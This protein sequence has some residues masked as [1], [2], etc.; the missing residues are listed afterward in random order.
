ME[1]M[2]LTQLIYSTDV[3]PPLAL[4]IFN[5]RGQHS[6]AK[7]FQRTPAY[8]DEVTTG[9]AKFMAELAIGAGFEVRITNS[10]DFLVFHAVG[11]KVQF[12]EDTAAFWR[13]LAE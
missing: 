10:D 12:P 6:G 5:A 8:P 13:K 9:R 2:E 11:G 4:Y 7:W 3:Q 1:R